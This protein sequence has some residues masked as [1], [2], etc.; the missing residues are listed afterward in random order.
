[1]KWWDGGA[2]EVERMTGDGGVVWPKGGRDERE[3][4][5]KRVEENRRKEGEKSTKTTTGTQKGK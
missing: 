5:S 4:K 3:S 1:V 2:R